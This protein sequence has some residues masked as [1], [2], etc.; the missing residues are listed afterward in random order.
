MEK[1]LLWQMK[2]LA[3]ESKRE[4]LERMEEMHGRRA[5]QLEAR[6]LDIQIKEIHA[7]MR[8]NELQQQ[9][10]ELQECEEALKKREEELLSRELG[11]T[12]EDVSA[13]TTRGLC[14]YVLL[15]LSFMN[16]VV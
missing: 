11:G 7:H 3:T 8:G 4:Y 15:V 10:E 16:H 5:R 9:E 1:A 12:N 6:E 14:V 2:I 13:M